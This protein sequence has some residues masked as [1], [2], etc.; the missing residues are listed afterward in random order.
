MP[1]RRHS[2]S[3]PADV[4]RFAPAKI[5]WFLH[6]LGRR[7]DGYHELRSLFLPLTLGDT[8]RVSLTE[9]GVAVKCPG[10][11]HLETPRNLAWRAAAAVS[12]AAG[13]TG[14][15]R[16]EIDKRI[17]E[18]AGLGG[19]SSDA[20]AVLLALDSLLGRPLG[21]ERLAGLALGLGADVPFFLDPKPSLVEGIGEKR[22]PLAGVPQLPMILLTFAEGLSTAD[23]FR[24]YDEHITS[25]LRLTGEHSNSNLK[26][27]ESMRAGRFA[28]LVHNDLQ[29]VAEE[30]CPRIE[31]ACTSLRRGGACVAAM[32]GSGPT[33]FG[34][35]RQEEDRDRAAALLTGEGPWRVIPVRVR[36]VEPPEVPPGSPEPGAANGN[37][38]R[39]L[40]A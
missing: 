19:G 31:R 12:R 38:G 35:F 39:G 16:I 32:T 2:G 30:C 27:A 15:V 3:R 14:G 28:D 9:G 20:A 33:V 26:L 6:V 24:A 11:P 5:N 7:G 22:R 1:Q 18:A 17:P 29:P 34:A 36:D 13:Y 23:I 21:D 40:G 4:E 25:K 8:V 37:Q 10:R